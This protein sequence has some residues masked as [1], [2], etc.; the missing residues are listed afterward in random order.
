MRVVPDTNIF[1]ISE[2]DYITIN[3]FLFFSLKKTR[4]VVSYYPVK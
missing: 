2:G 3:V 4:V 1:T